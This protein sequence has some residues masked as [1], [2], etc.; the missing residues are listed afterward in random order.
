MADR[1]TPLAPLRRANIASAPSEHSMASTPGIATDQPVAFSG[2]ASRSPQCRTSVSPQDL[3][4]RAIAHALNIAAV[5]HGQRGQVGMAARPL[6]HAAPA[7][8]VCSATLA[9]A[10]ANAT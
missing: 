5:Y 4:R 3:S 1:V 7:N 6:D 9:H 2:V 10:D 8:I